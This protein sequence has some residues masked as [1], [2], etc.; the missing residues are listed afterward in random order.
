MD[1]SEWHGRN[2]TASDTTLQAILHEAI[3]SHVTDAN[4]HSAMIKLEQKCKANKV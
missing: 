1:D 2:S 4:E 3:R